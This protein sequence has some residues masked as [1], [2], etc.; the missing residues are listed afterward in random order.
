MVDPLPTSSSSIG[1]VHKHNDITAM[2]PKSVLAGR[3]AAPSFVLPAP[4][5]VNAQFLSE[6]V[7]EVGLCLFETQTCLAYGQ[8]DLPQALSVLPL[9]WHAHLPLDL[10]WP[11]HIRHT[12]HPART[13][14][15]ASLAILKKITFLRPRYAILHPPDGPIYWQRRLLADFLYFWHDATQ[16]PL[17]LE[18]TAHC[19]ILSLGNSFLHDTGVGLCLDVGHLLGYDQRCLFTSDL[20]EQAALLHWSA[21]GNHD[22]HL[23]LTAMTASQQRTAAT[24]AARVPRTATHMIEVFNWNGYLASLPLLAQLVAACP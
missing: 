8:D 5:A 3:L 9:R 13:A 11:E 18:N 2:L 24:L 16:L 4:I 1:T 19:D 10:L 12:S 23:P 21:P 22:R 14:A 20:P 7:D 6:K 17:L 15:H